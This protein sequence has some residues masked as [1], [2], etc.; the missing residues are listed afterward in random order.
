VQQNTT[1]PAVTHTWT[2]IW[3]WRWQLTTISLNFIR[4]YSLLNSI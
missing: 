4:V 2:D 3:L 1:T